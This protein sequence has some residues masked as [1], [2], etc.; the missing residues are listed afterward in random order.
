MQCREFKEISEAY[1]SDALLP[2]TNI[3]VLGHLENCPAC[4][5]DFASRRELRETLRGAVKN[6]AEFQISPAFAARLDV[7]LRD[8]ALAENRRF[9][10]LFAPKIFAPAFAALFIVLTLGFVFLRSADNSV[11]PLAQTDNGSRTRELVKISATAV[12][13]HEEC[14]LEKLQRWEAMAKQDFAEKAV[15]TEKIV[16]PLRANFSEKVELLHAHDCVFEGKRL[17]HVILR[18]D[19]HIVSVFFDKS[20]AA[21]PG[22]LTTA[23]IVCEKE[24][25]FQVASFQNESRAVFVVSDLSEAENLSAA[26]ALSDSMQNV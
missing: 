16:K 24:S 23:S 10:F 6:A 25:G 5:A 15:Y 4:R 3:Q 26:R 11:A 19:G 17:T 1:L 13:S 18:K 22:D 14:A 12:V 21:S 2:E 9:G 7:K 20:V 8:A